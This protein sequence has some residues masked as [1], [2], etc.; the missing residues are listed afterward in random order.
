MA[1]DAK[2]LSDI[3]DASIYDFSSRVRYAHEG[4]FVVMQNAAG[5]FATL[6]VVDVRDQER[7]DNCDELTFDYWIL[8]DKTRDFSS[9]RNF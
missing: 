2:R 8:T 9:K 5:Y 3:V 1:V 6:Y 4:Q 7:S